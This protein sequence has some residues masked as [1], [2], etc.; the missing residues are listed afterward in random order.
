MSGKTRLVTIRVSEDEHDSWVAEAGRG[1]VSGWLRGLAEAAVTERGAVA[2]PASGDPTGM[3]S[4]T[5]GI[6]PPSNPGL[7]PR[8]ATAAEDKLGTEPFG[9]GLLRSF[10]SD[11]KKPR[12]PKNG[13]R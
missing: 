7:T 3:G 2:V 6:G 12:A 8:S 1:N 13:R 5:G 9:T 11:F 4:R 10:K